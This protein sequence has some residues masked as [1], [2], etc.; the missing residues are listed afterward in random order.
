MISIYLSIYLSIYITQT[1]SSGAN[2]KR[3]PTRSQYFEH[4]A[5]HVWA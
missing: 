1:V 2:T 4:V 5:G 3:R